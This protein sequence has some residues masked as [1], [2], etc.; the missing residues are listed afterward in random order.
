MIEEVSILVSSGGLTKAGLAEEEWSNGSTGLTEVGGITSA[1]LARIGE[2]TET[3]DG[4]TWDSSTESV[5]LWWRL[6]LL[7]LGSFRRGLFGAEVAEGRRVPA[8]EEG[9]SDSRGTSDTWSPNTE[10]RLWSALSG[11]ASAKRCEDPGAS[12]PRVLAAV[13]RC[14]D[15]GS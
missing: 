9:A 10:N 6:G 4:G 11:D 15:G 1:E 13:G 8:A 14:S 2:P 5:E 3:L 12:E 7:F